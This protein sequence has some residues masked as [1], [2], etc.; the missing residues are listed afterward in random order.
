MFFPEAHKE[1]QNK[2]IRP[3]PF[4]PTH[5]WIPID[6]TEEFSETVHKLFFSLFL[7]K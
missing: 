4:L 5:Y 3:H 7:S 1:R 2:T 6:R